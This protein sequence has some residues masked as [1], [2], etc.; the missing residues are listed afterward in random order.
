MQNKPNPQN[1]E[2]NLT[3][4][5]KEVY[6]DSPLPRPQKNKP[7]TNPIQ[8]NPQSAP[9]PTL[10]NPQSKPPSHPE[11]AS[12]SA[13][14]NLAFGIWNLEFSPQTLSPKSA[15]FSLSAFQLCA[16]TERNHHPFMQN[17]PNPKTTKTNLT[18]Y[19]KKLYKN[20]PLPG[21][22][23]NKPNSNPIPAQTNPINPTSNPNQ[24]QSPSPL[25]FPPCPLPQSPNRT[26]AHD[27]P[28]APPQ[29]S[30]SNPNPIRYP[31]HATRC[32]AIVL[33]TLSQIW[34]NRIS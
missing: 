31:L 21:N 4:Y 17:K 13:F 24:T 10:P 1:Q 33:D 19:P 15:Q 14:R 25:N 12:G 7:K 26:R 20:F 18:L 3:P 34:D 11:L 22:E 16:K 27:D 9:R 8:P 2:P 6:T 32:K 29:R 28:P 30:E 23:K 5:P